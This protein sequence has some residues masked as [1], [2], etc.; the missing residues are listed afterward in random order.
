[1]LS[2]SLKPQGSGWAWGVL[3]IDGEVIA[4]GAAADRIAAQAAIRIAYS[5][6]A[7]A[8]SPARSV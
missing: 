2:Y 3:D 8:S 6:A 7:A 1:M 4:H 5:R